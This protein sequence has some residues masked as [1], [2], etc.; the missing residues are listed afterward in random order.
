MTLVLDTGALIQ[1]DRGN[2]HILSMIETALNRGERV[3]VPAGVIGQAWRDPSRRAR[4]SRALRRC[5]EVDLTG[6]RARASG[7]LCG[8]A[9]TSDVIDASVAVAVA[10]A[11]RRDPHV[12]LLTS[13]LH[14][15]NALL[16]AVRV[17]ARVVDV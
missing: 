2:R 14:D 16:A 4:L 13:D 12:S 15:L 8:E 6:S 7:Q 5:D 3:H 9:G 17:G 11:S 1:V 10:E